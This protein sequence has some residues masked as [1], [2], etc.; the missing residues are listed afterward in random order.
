MIV[1]TMM[2]V[3]VETMGMIMMVMIVQM[4]ARMLAR[5][6]VVRVVSFVGIVFFV[7]PTR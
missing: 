4:V 5:M 1:E 6:L 2:V 7:V 3:I